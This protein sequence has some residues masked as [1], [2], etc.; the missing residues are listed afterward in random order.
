M[1][2]LNIDEKLY[3][4]AQQYPEIVDIM[5]ELG[6]HEIKIS[7]M[8]STAGRM[9]TIPVGAKMKHIE[10]DKIVRAFEANGFE[11]ISRGE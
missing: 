3:D 8:L 11:F 4:L 7:G 6:F 9:V 1:I 5:D 2:Q 10:W